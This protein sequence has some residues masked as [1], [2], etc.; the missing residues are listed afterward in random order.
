MCYW[1]K[2]AGQALVNDR[3][4]CENSKLVRSQKRIFFSSFFTIQQYRRRLASQSLSTP[5]NLYMHIIFILFSM[6]LILQLIFHFVPLFLLSPSR[7][8]N[9]FPFFEKKSSWRC[10][11]RFLFAV[12]SPHSCF[13]SYIFQEENEAKKRTTSRWTHDTMIMA[14]MKIE[15]VRSGPSERATATRRDTLTAEGLAVGSIRGSLDVENREFDKVGWS[16]ALTIM[17]FELW[18]DWF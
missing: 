3:E 16:L 5:H 7:A 18:I 10:H 6:K 14:G 11:T 17:M 4:P 1:E 13:S 12:R 9:P 8:L 2:N 15:I